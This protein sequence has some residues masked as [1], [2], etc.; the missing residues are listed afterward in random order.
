MGQLDVIAE[1]IFNTEFYEEVGTPEYLQDFKARI[2]AWLETNIGQLNILI[3]ENFRVDENNDVCPRL[4]AEEI[5]IFIQ[6]YLKFY[7]KRQSQSILKNLSTTTTT[8]GSGTPVYTMSDWTELREGDSSIKRVSQNASPQQK[9][10][11][12]QA[13]KG[14]SEE[15][16]IKLSELVH[17]YNMYRS[18]PKQVVSM[19]AGASECEIEN[20]T[21]E[22]PVIT[23]T[24]TG[25]SMSNAEDQFFTT[26]KEVRETPTP[27]KISGENIYPE[28]DGMMFSAHGD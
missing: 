1:N 3:N 22:N 28:D 7:Y 12:A 14:F 25:V 27:E 15:A 9:V 10:Q 19:E 4:K 13:Y 26:Q 23:P 17:S 5:A 16:D 20:R 18:R 2:S 21:C 6:L 11:V 8:S 24:P